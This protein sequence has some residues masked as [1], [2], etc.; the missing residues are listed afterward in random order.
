MFIFGNACWASVTAPGV[1]FF[2]QEKGQ[3][4]ETA[5]G[6]PWVFGLLEENRMEASRREMTDRQKGGGLYFCSE[7]LQCPGT[8][9]FGRRLLAALASPGI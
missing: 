8:E 2:F 4:T 3:E 6:L 9:Q 1:L 5:S 7:A